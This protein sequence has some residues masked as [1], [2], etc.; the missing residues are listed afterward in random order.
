MFNGYN[1]IKFKALK[2]IVHKLCM[3]IFIFRCKGYKILLRDYIRFVNR[4]KINAT[5]RI[6]TYP[7]IS[8]AMVK[9]YVSMH[10]SDI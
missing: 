10:S 9:N 2:E 3:L 4:V 8:L 1:L 7:L 6:F 5:V